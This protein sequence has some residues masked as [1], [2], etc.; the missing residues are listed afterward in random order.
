[1]FKHTSDLKSNNYKAHLALL[2]A[3]IIYALNYGWAKDVMQG[4]YLEPFAF[5]LLRAIGATLLFWLVS[6]FFWEKVDKKDKIKLLLCGVFGVA[7]NQLLFFKGLDQTTRINASIIMVAS[8]IIVALLSAIIIKEKPSLYRIVGIL[9][10]LTGA[11]LIILQGNSSSE[12]ASLLGNVLIILNATSYGLYLVLVKPLMKKYSPITV[13]KWVFTFGLAIV[14][15][16]G[17]TEVNTIVWE[18]PSDI[19]LKVG[20]V[21]VFTTFFTYLFNIYGVKRV[22]PTVVSSYI[23]LQ[24]IL[25]SLIAAFSG[26]ETI[27]SLMIISSIV[28]FIG[29]YLVSKP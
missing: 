23:Y 1:L 22:S 21:I 13:I 4:G 18:M 5:I 6:F 26:T 2:L 27:T 29:V 11:C 19:V 20:F 24:P 16:F 7:A 28:I 17:L 10:G 8:P 14:T 9:L 15:P 3:N 12:G 25:T